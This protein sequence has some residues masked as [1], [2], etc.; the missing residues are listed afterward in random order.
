MAAIVLFPLACL[1]RVKSGIISEG[2]KRLL[3]AMMSGKYATPPPLLLLRE[4]ITLPCIAG[5]GTTSGT[6]PLPLSGHV[7]HS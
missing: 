6:A 4:R 5:R 1:E 2:E 7:C 3:G